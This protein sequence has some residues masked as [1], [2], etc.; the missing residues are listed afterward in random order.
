[1]M[2]MLDVMSSLGVRRGLVS[3]LCAACV[4]LLCLACG[5]SDGERQ[6]M[7]LMQEVREQRRLSGLDSL[8]AHTLRRPQLTTQTFRRSMQ[9]HR[10]GEPRRMHPGSSLNVLTDA[11]YTPIK[12]VVSVEGCEYT[13]MFQHA[14][15][16]DIIWPGN[17][18][19]LASAQRNSP[20]EVAAL[21]PY[22]ASGR[23]SLAVVNG[24]TDLVEEVSSF[25]KSSVY[26][27]LNSLIKKNKGG[28]PA[29]LTFSSHSVRSESEMAYFMGVTRDEYNQNYRSSF[30]GVRWG[31]NTYKMLVQ[32]RQVFFTVVFDDP[33]PSASR[34]FRG[35]LT[36]DKFKALNMGGAPL[37][38]ISSVSYGR[39]FV[40]LI[41]EKRRSYRDEAD[42]KM[43]VEAYN[44]QRK[45][46]SPSAMPSPEVNIF[47]RQIGGK[48]LP[49]EDILLKSP[50]KL[51]AFLAEHA[52]FGPDNIGYP[53]A[54]RL[55]ALGDMK[56]VYYKNEVK[57]K[58]EFVD[59]ELVE[60]A[61]KVTIGGITIDIQGMGTKTE[62]GNYPEISNHSFFRLHLCKISITSDDAKDDY[63]AY[64]QRY[65][66]ERDFSGINGTR[67][68]IPF[69]FVSPELG[70]TPKARI[71]M[72]LNLMCHA[73]RY[74][75]GL[76]GG[77]S[78]VKEH[79][80][81]IFVWF[82][83]D[84]SKQRW[85]VDYTGANQF[86]DFRYFGVTDRLNYCPV[87]FR[88]NYSF[89]TEQKQY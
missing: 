1:M 54:Y 64:T 15:P 76:F 24:Q 6:T 11:F 8:F 52:R 84:I 16:V 35:G 21:Q 56:P 29:D 12:R 32:L 23:I 47:V 27:A 25:D 57:D 70:R 75:N 63:G 68:A 62:G 61:N 49:V 3:A 39:S 74:S 22:R 33:S 28:L 50:D 82:W 88:V 79:D 85:V 34:L 69:T 19:D 13:D 71:L 26:E 30:S 67:I 38:Y 59:Y 10:Q 60:D 2:S 43:A 73:Q 36:V 81:K 31:E 87:R 4:A 55:K 86:E 44:P 89:R 45:A 20:I 58:Y 9:T 41:E 40:M 80:Y 14:L 5:Q 78:K 17:I 66:G 77:G 42:M 37:G 18:I 51:L 72:E 7:K 83:Y 48:T 65:V 46:T 53:I